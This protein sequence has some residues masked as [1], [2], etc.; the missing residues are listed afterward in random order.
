MISSPLKI[1][2][3]TC[4]S[5]QCDS[6]DAYMHFEIYFYAICFDSCFSEMFDITTNLYVASL[7]S[8]QSKNPIDSKDHW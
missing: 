7:L 6:E 8:F 1:I 5:N 4:Q 3:S 2:S